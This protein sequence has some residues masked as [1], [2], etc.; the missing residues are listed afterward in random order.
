MD[1]TSSRDDGSDADDAAVAAVAA[2]AVVLAVVALPLPVA[3]TRASTKEAGYGGATTDEE[4][5]VRPLV[6]P[7]LRRGLT[8]RQSPFVS[9]IG[10]R[11]RRD[12]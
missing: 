4:R 2:A 7:A 12:C 3:E 11:R 1:V 6:V 10:R 8:N 5:E 9:F